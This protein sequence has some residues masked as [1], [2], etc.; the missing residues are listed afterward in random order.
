MTRWLFFQILTDLAWHDPAKLL[1]R[2]AALEEENEKLRQ[3]IQ[4]SNDTVENI[5]FFWPRL[6]WLIGLLLFQSLSSIV[7]KNFHEVM[8]A[9]PSIVYFLT[10]LV[11]AGG[12]VGGQSAVLV[13]RALATKRPVPSQVVTGV[14]LGIFLAAV[15]L[16]RTLVQGVEIMTA[17]ALTLS[18]FCIVAVACSMGQ[19]FPMFFYMVG[20]DPAHSSATV[21][22]FMDISGITLTCIIVSLMLSTTPPPISTGTVQNGNITLASALS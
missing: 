4:T 13:V 18:M 2:I 12:N 10:M 21:Q 16:I 5:Q 1:A 22:V 9:H 11:G 3:N 19:F 15:T 8:A 17:V 20:I 6:G 14:K 7:L